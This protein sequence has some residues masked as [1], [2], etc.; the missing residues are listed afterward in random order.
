[1]GGRDLCRTQNSKYFVVDNFAFYKVPF[2]LEFL[3]CLPL[4]YRDRIRHCYK[5]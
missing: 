2:R 5:E 1:M 3:I 4:K